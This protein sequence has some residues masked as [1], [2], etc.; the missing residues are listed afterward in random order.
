MDVCR[1]CYVLSGRGLCDGLITRPEDS[2]RLWCVVVCDLETSWMSWPWPTG[3]WGGG[4]GCRA[5]TNKQTVHT[6]C[7]LFDDPLSVW[8]YTVSVVGWLMIIKSEGF[9]SKFSTRI[10]T[11]LRWRQYR[12]W[13]SGGPPEESVNIA[14]VSVEIP[15]GH[16]TNMRVGLHHYTFLLH[17]LLSAPLLLLHIQPKC[18]WVCGRLV[19]R[20]LTCIPDG[21]L[22]SDIYQMIYWYSW[23]SWWWAL[24]CS[25]LVQKWN[26]HTKKCV[27]L[28]INTN[29][30]G[31]SFSEQ[32]YFPFCPSFHPKAAYSFMHSF[33]HSLVTHSV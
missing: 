27:K 5:K 26:K 22:Q 25:K 12:S 16:I 18:T 1:E 6:E 28:V 9:R 30:T 10:L 13:G 23:F 14:Y 11:S 21:H 32:N 17:L 15:T 29:Y 2:Y 19:C 24:G 20:S 4:E 3:G 31:T 33:I 8:K 7:S